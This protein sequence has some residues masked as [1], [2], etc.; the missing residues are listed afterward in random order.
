MVY[1]FFGLFL[2]MLWWLADKGLKA[3]FNPYLKYGSLVFIAILVASDVF[4]FVETQRWVD[5]CKYETTGHCQGLT[6]SYTYL[7]GS[8]VSTT[9]TTT[10]YGEYSDNTGSLMAYNASEY[11]IIELFYNYLPYIAMFVIVLLG[12]Q[13]VSLG[14]Y[15]ALD[16]KKND[17]GDSL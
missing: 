5:T 15:E 12:L 9:H 4:L 8:N 16:G 13:Y 1:L 10:A 3:R 7:N 11:G 17:K 2:L 6:Y 14:Y